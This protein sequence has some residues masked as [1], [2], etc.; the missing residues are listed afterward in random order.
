MSQVFPNN[1]EKRPRPTT[2]TNNSFVKNVTSRVS[3]LLPTT[4]TKWFSSPSSSNAN[5]SATIFDASD[6]SEDEAPDAPVITQPPAKRMR[7]SSPGS[8]SHYGPSEAGCSTNDVDIIDLPYSPF[9]GP[10]YAPPS[11]STF[12]T[13]MRPPNEESEPLDRDSSH[14]FKMPHTVSSIGQ[15]VAHKRKSIF[16]TTSPEESVKGVAKSATSTMRDPKQP[17]FKPSLLGSPFYPGRTMYGGAASSSYINQPNIKR[18]T[19]AVVNESKS[20]DDTAISS[21]ARRIMDLLESYSSPLME[22]RRIPLYIKPKNDG[23]HNTSSDRSSP[24]KNKSLS[25]KTQELH[26]PSIASILRLKKKSRLMDTTNAARQIIASHSSAS[27]YPLYPTESKGKEP[28]MEQPHKMTTKVKARVTRTNRESADQYEMVTPVKLPTGVL[29]LDQDKLPHFSFATPAVSMQPATSTPKIAFTSA[30]KNNTAVSASIV[31]EPESSTNKPK[32]WSC[33]DCWV[34]NKPEATKCVCCGSKQPVQNVKCS[35]CKL[36]DSQSQKDKC[37]NCEKMSVSKVLSPLTPK[38]TGS[39]SSKWMCEDCWVSNEDS[40]AKCVCCGCS[41]PRKPSSTVSSTA[42]SSTSTSSLQASSVIYKPVPVKAV[43]ATPKADAD[44]KCD[45]CWISNKSSVDKCAACGGARPGAKQTNATDVTPNTNSF[46]GSSDHKFKN[47]VKSQKAEKWECSSC[48]VRNEMEKDKCVCCGAEKENKKKLPDSKFNFGKTVNNSFK[49]G[50]DPKVQEA[51]IT[52]KPEIISTLDSKLKAQ[53]ETN[54][55]VLAETPTFTFTLPN[56]KVESKTDATPAKADEAPKMNFTFGIPKTIPTSTA[57]TNKVEPSKDLEDEKFQEVPSVDLNAPVQS[58]PLVMSP[59]TQI[60][61]DNKTLT[62]GTVLN[63]QLVTDAKKDTPLNS[64]DLG[65]AST[66]EKPKPAFTFGVTPSTKMFEAPA[67]TGSSMNLFTQPAQTVAATS[68]P[69]LPMFKPPETS[70]P[71]TSLFQ[72]PD[73]TPKP[74]PL[75]AT[76]E[77]NNNTAAV[78]MFSF[79]NNTSSNLAPPAVLTLPAAPE[80]PKFQFTFGSNTTPKTD[81]PAMFKSPF[82]AGEG[83]NT[84][85]STFN[86]PTGN[87]LGANN[88]LPTNAL[89]GSNGLTAPN[90]LTGNAMAGSSLGS[91]AG[92]SLSSNTLTMGNGG[93]LGGTN[94]LSTNQLTGVSSMQPGNILT[95]AAPSL[96]NNTVQKENVWAPSSAAQQTPNLFVSN[97]TASSLQKPSTF[98]FGSS[99]MFNAASSMPTFGTTAAPPQNIFGMNSQTNNTQSSMF[100]NPVASPPTGNLFGSPPAASNATPPMPMFGTTNIGAPPAF[101]SPNPSIPSFEAPSHAPAPAP[102]FNFGAP[103]ST[104]IFG[105]GQQPQLQQQQQ[106]QQQQMQQQQQ[107]LQHQA[108]PQQSGVYSFGG[109]PAGAPQVQFSMGSGANPAVRRVRKA[110][111][112]NPQR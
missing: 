54:N 47:I 98:T 88:N 29:R 84:T 1:K 43:P 90:G 77:S 99:T 12:T 41:R 56:K 10:Q 72:P 111:R 108:S 82:G 9:S 79:G 96:F 92:N 73:L 81:P 22:A 46:F 20:N 76:N 31:K 44:W 80:K 74:A 48:L 16:D 110:V 61:N 65:G 21:S 94:G 28:E 35:I 107:L 100:S 106:M 37:A 27:N 89:G 87:T 58:K 83:S 23:F 32:D 75:F 26:V 11:R 25:Y 70:A 101:G 97:S 42:T 38:P 49:F 78:P 14:V 5:G 53:S 8:Y 67:S 64:V 60:N 45:D 57:V 36:A 68:A 15:S 85:T 55:N 91:M 66:A 52:K 18:Q 24:Y 62:A 93:T 59:I 39:S 86:L 105:F 69:T 33:S 13:P 7:F 50:I 40:V 6:S 71:A 3:G 95:G 103:Q 2:E 104:G 19:V 112:R 4:I 102:A 34:K 109:A 17:S 30:D 63:A 51:N